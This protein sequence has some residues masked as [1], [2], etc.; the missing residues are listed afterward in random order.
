MG[1]MVNGRVTQLLQG[2]M[3]ATDLIETSHEQFDV[4]FGVEVAGTVLI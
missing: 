1:S 4:R 3:S 2:R